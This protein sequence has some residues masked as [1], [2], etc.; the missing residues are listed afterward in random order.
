LELSKNPQWDSFKCQQ[1]FEAINAWLQ[2]NVVDVDQLLKV[3]DKEMFK[4]VRSPR[5]FLQE[6]KYRAMY[7]PWMA[8]QYKLM[9]TLGLGFNGG[10]AAIDSIAQCRLVLHLYNAF[11]I[12]GIFE[13]PIPL[14]ETLTDAL[15]KTK[16]LWVAGRPTKPG[17]FMKGFLLAFGH[18]IKSAAEMA[19]I[20][21]LE[22]NPK[23]INYKGPKAKELV[24][25]TSSEILS[26]FRILVNMDSSGLDL[27][28]GYGQYL[29]EIKPIIAKEARLFGMNLFFLGKVFLDI[30]NALLNELELQV[31]VQAVIDLVENVALE[32]GAPKKSKKGKKKATVKDYRNSDENLRFYSEVWVLQQ[33]FGFCDREP[34]KQSEKGNLQLQKAGE[35]IQRILGTLKESD[36]MLLK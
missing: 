30:W 23:M 19:S 27:D 10:L 18:S 29:D 5:Q 28:K 16:A 8:G 2:L 33:L 17:D 32:N 20:F 24:P 12:K 3:V 7:N 21:A 22:D 34:D 14:L 11:R 6:M 35:I 13:K 1:N 15:S 4:V 31:K 26:T 9:I 25:P 36:Y